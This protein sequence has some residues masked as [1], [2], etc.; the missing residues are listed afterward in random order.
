[1]PTGDGAGDGDATATGARTAPVARLMDEHLPQQ[2]P[3]GDP[4]AAFERHH[5]I[6]LAE[7]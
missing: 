2:Y 3:E 5:T 1:M 4:I 6:T 7:G